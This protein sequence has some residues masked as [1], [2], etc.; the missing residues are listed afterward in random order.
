LGH[1]G[2]IDR[3]ERLGRILSLFQDRSLGSRQFGP[4]AR[5]AASARASGPPSSRPT[6]SRGA[7][8]L[9]RAILRRPVPGRRKKRWRSDRP[10]TASA[11]A[12]DLQPRI[13]GV[14]NSMIG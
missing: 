1:I 14:V 5:R 10:H 4:T 12:N 11:R 13:R 9:R 3:S 6:R 7:F 2:K 8:S